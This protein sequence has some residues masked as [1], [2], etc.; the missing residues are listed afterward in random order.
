VV[1]VLLCDRTGLALHRVGVL[2][3]LEAHLLAGRLDRRLAAGWPVDGDHLLA[4]RARVLLHPCRRHSLAE[5]LRK[6]VALAEGRRA[7]HRHTVP[8]DRARVGPCAAELRT[9]AD[10]LD[11]TAPIAPQTVAWTSTLLVDGT[12]PLYRRDDPDELRLE[13]MAAL[14]VAD[15]LEPTAFAA[16]ASV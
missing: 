10:R 6:V 4:A 11:A 5:A 15:T 7:P 2:R 3:R 9:L 8:V 12:G 1:E 14:G 16:F 13:L